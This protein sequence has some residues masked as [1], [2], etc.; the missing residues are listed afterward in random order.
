LPRR[1]TPLPARLLSRRRFVGG[2]LAVAAT[3]PLLPGAAR[4]QEKTV[5]VY[6]WD[7]YIGENTVE[8]FTEATG[9]KVRYDLFASNEEMFAKLRAGNPGYDVIFAT[10]NWVERM[11]VGGMLEPL[12]HG[13]LPN[14]ANIDPAFA[15]PAFDPGCKHA[16]PYFWGTMG[17]GYRKSDKN[18][19]RWADLFGPEHSQGKMAVLN[20]VNSLR[21]VL[22]YLGYSLN[23]TDQKQ[24][25][26]AAQVLIKA[27]P[28]IKAFAPDTG[29][30]LLVSGEVDMCLEWS[31]DILQVMAEDEE[32]DYVVPEEGS[33][34]WTD[35]ML[36]P[37]GAPNP[38]NALAFMNF[39]LDAEVGAEIAQE[40]KCASPNRAAKELLPAED[41]DNPAIYPPQAVLAKCEVAIYQ[42]EAVDGLYETAMTR[43]LAA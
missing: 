21:C 32:L 31:G 15:N 17:I 29:Q 1:P 34:L 40:V 8:Q 28:W 36:M 38:E 18:P 37:K 12:D 6:N 19:S 11:I 16:M 35:S 20:D 42:G 26:E 2:T 27:K 7:T 25:D 9:I 3:V 14:F 10:N 39:I 23:T 13:K 22:K 33:L 43:V 5:N 41:R 30:D 24:I 4:A